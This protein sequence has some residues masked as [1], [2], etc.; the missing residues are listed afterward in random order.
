[1]P[2]RRSA[3]LGFVALLA[4]SG[5]A[6]GGHE[7]PVYP[8]YYPHEITIETVP[9]EHAAAL[10]GEAKLH[11]Y[12][13]S[14]MLFP[15]GVPKTV[16]AIELLG[17]FLIVRVNPEQQD[18]A[19]ACG[20][21]DAV[22]RDMAGRSG[23]VFH[24]YPVTPFD[25]DYIDH[26]DLAD[27]EKARL[28][29][30]PAAPPRTLRVKAEGAA[31]DL[32]RPE[33]RA[34]GNTWDAAV[35]AVDAAQLIAGSRSVLDGWLGPPWLKSGW[36]HAERLLSDAAADAASRLRNAAL[37]QRLEHGEYRNAVERVN[38]ERALVGALN[39]GCGKRVAGYTIDRQ[40]FSAEFTEGIENI[41]FDS[42]DGLNSP[43]FI[44]TVKLKDFPWNGRLKLGIDASPAAAWNPIAGFGDPF[45]RLLWSAIGD[46]ALL[47]TPYDSSWMLNRISD[48]QSS[49]GR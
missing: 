25:G 36:F 23:F 42:V 29:S 19:V 30:A 11:A 43:L 4:T 16:R 12:L 49:A 46:P 3:L 35:E 9:P 6:R 37:V 31:A 39:A 22:I 20:T 7:V 21:L 41:G 38:L 32:I 44:R 34:S 2:A 28:S 45:G 14:E 26:V 5:L 8:S 47:P 15:N 48:V 27:A 1:M 18:E 33:W 13:G 24:P 10:L 17:N 40:Y